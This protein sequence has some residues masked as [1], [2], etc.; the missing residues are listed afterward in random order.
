MYHLTAVALGWRDAELLLEQNDFKTLMSSAIDELA[1]AG[2]IDEPTAT[3]KQ[4]RNAMGALAPYS[5]GGGLAGIVRKLRGDPAKYGTSWG[6]SK[7]LQTLLD[8]GRKINEAISVV[9][10]MREE[11]FSAARA[12]A[13]AAEARSAYAGLTVY[14]PFDGAAAR[15]HRPITQEKIL[16]NG[17]VSLMTRVPVGEPNADGFYPVN[18]NGREVPQRRRGKDGKWQ[19]VIGKDGKP[20]M[21][22]VDTATRPS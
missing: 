20:K 7:N 6:D 11:Y 17:A 2:K 5:Y 1:K 8:E 21:R 3:P 13:T 10:R 19:D 14:D 4:R 15:W 22:R 18:Y 12:L 9:V 16:R